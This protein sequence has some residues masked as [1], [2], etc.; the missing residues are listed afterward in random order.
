MWN[1]HSFKGAIVYSRE[2]GSEIET[3]FFF[4][5]KERGNIFSHIARGY[6]FPGIDQNF[7][8]PSR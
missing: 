4:S 1:S 3:K 7:Q 5:S 6:I 2:G 8:I